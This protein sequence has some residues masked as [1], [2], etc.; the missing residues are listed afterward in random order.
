MEFFTFFVISP[1]PFPQ[2]CQ[3][4]T[5]QVH[6]ENF[7]PQLPYHLRKPLGI[8][9]A[10]RHSI[11]QWLPILFISPCWIFFFKDF[12]FFIGTIF[13][14]FV[15]FVTILH[16]FYVLDFWPKGMSS[17]LPDQGSNLHP[18]ESKA[19]TTGP[20]EKSPLRWILCVADTQCPHRARVSHRP[21]SARSLPL[22]PAGALV[23]SPQPPTCC[24]P[25]TTSSRL[26]WERLL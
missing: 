7:S 20:T 12:F 25:G 3:E 10:D 4:A 17:S 8:P 23:L 6:A 2:F 22:P 9:V 24:H 26:T 11:H 18:L 16:L 5:A 1:G 15:E 19:S 14:A 13:K 21:L